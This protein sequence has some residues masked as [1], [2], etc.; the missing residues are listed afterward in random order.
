MENQETNSEQVLTNQELKQK[1][2]K[3]IK[4]E[5]IAK[6]PKQFKIE[7]QGIEDDN[8]YYHPI[9]TLSDEFYIHSQCDLNTKY[10]YGFCLKSNRSITIDSLIYSPV[11]YL[12]DDKMDYFLN[13][14]T[15]I[16]EKLIAAENEIFKIYSLIGLLKESANKISNT[17]IDEIID[18][19][20]L[21]KSIRSLEEVVEYLENKRL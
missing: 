19:I 16:L 2:W 15:K 4:K 6:I 8:K 17:V 5:F 3:S 21:K 11:I 13:N 9:I 14:Y 10:I 18:K 1:H 7:I 20:E 12:Y